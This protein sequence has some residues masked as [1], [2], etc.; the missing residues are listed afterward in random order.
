MQVRDHN[1]GTRASICL[2]CALQ[3]VAL[4]TSPMPRL[5]L[6]AVALL[7]ASCTS[8][9]TDAS[10][11]PC[12]VTHRLEGNKLIATATVTNESR[13]TVTFVDHADFYIF[14]LEAANPAK[15]RQ[16]VHPLL[17]HFIR[18]TREHLVR[19]APGEQ[20]RFDWPYT[21]HRKGA[22]TSELTSP[23]FGIRTWDSRLRVTFKY[24]ASADYLP[25]HAWAL[26]RNY[27]MAKLKA[28]EV[29]PWP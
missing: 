11:L 21:I 12:K 19:V 10:K 28:E 2:L 5:V 27:V 20:I 18:A 13:S 29:F 14:D 4:L 25:K 17:I 1:G 26:G 3:R 16:I 23:F 7:L 22:G 24:G 6:A 15:Q 8:T 9:F